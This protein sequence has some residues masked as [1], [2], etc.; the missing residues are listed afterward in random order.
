MFAGGTLFGVL[1]ALPRHAV[2]QVSTSLLASTPTLDV[3]GVVYVVSSSAEEDGPNVLAFNGT[4]GV[5]LWNHTVPG[6]P[7]SSSS[8]SKDGTLYVGTTNGQLFA[9][10]DYV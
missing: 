3:D 10:H 2:W 5:Q 1:A 8:L 4:T 6:V 9:L 7:S